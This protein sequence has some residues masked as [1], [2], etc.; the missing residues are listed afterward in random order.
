MNVPG[1][2][3]TPVITGNSVVYSGGT[4]PPVRIGEALPPARVSFALPLR[5]IFPKL[6]APATWKASVPSLSLVRL[7]PPA[8]RL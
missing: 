5:A 7:A 4:Y 2:P 8:V 1:V 3:V 6:A